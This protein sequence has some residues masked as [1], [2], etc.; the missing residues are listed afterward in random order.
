MP[1]ASSGPYPLIVFSHG[2]SISRSTTSYLME[3]LASYGFVVMAVNHPGGTFRD[4]IMLGFGSPELEAN[5]PMSFVQWVLDDMSIIEF[6]AEL[7]DTEGDFNGLIDLERIGAAGYSFGGNV[8][9]Q[10]AGAHYNLGMVGEL[11]AEH[12]NAPEACNLPDIESDLLTLAGVEQIEGNMWS[13]VD[14]PVVDAVVGLAPGSMIPF[15][16]EGLAMVDV[17]ALIISGSIDNLVPPA[18]TQLTYDSISSDT[19]SL[20][21]LENAGHFVFMDCDWQTD[22]FIMMCADRVWDRNRAYDL[23]NHFSTALFLS[24]LYDDMDARD[25]LQ[26]VQIPGVN[27]ETVIGN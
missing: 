4:Q 22:A 21:W 17:P 6:A 7:N 23:V 24:A 13:V 9:F 19:K 10:L 1:N 3:H 14:D 25:A 16:A 5:I 8:A 15:G 20:V 2:W 27:Y 26:S 11:C 12:T 18:L